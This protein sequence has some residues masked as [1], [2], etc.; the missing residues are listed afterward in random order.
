MVEQSAGVRRARNPIPERSL[1]DRVVAGHHAL[2]DGTSTQGAIDF[3]CHPGGK[4]HDG[5]IAQLNPLGVR[6]GKTY[7][8]GPGANV[9]HAHSRCLFSANHLRHTRSV[10]SLDTRNQPYLGF[11]EWDLQWN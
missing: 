2:Q 5:A 4:T 6:S 8:A 10:G 7:Q 11:G 3:A 9:Q 1:V